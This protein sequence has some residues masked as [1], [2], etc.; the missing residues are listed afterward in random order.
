MKKLRLIILFIILFQVLFT[1]VLMVNATVQYVPVELYPTWTFTTPTNML[2]YPL[3]TNY[4]YDGLEFKIRGWEQFCEVTDG[5]EIVTAKPYDGAQ[6]P[7]NISSEGTNTRWLGW[8]LTNLGN[9]WSDEVIW[10]DLTEDTAECLFSLLPNG[11][12]TLFYESIP[13]GHQF[14][15]SSSTGAGSNWA[16]TSNTIFTVGDIRVNVIEGNSSTSTTMLTVNASAS[17]KIHVSL[18]NRQFFDGKAINELGALDGTYP[19]EVV[20]RSSY[21]KENSLHINYVD[22]SIDTYLVVNPV[23]TMMTGLQLFQ[24]ESLPVQDRYFNFGVADS[25]NGNM[26]THIPIMSIPAKI[27][28]NH[29]LHHA[30]RRWWIQASYLSPYTSLMGNLLFKWY[31]F[32]DAS[33][34]AVSRITDEITI[35]YYSSSNSLLLYFPVTVGDRHEGNG[36]AD[37]YGETQNIITSKVVWAF[38]D[39]EFIEGF[40][41]YVN[42]YF[43]IDGE[44]GNAIS[45]GWKNRLIGSNTPKDI[46]YRD[47]GGVWSSETPAGSWTWRAGNGIFNMLHNDDSQRQYH[48]CR[49]WDGVFS[50]RTWQVCDIR[51]VNNQDSGFQVNIV[52]ADN[53]TAGDEVFG[54]LR[55]IWEE[56]SSVPSDAHAEYY[57]DTWDLSGVA[58]IDGLV[59]LTDD[60]AST[61]AS[62]DLGYDS[63]GNPQIFYMGPYNP[64]NPNVFKAGF[65]FGGLMGI[66]IPA[67]L[68]LWKRPR[69]DVTV[70]LCMVMIFGLAFLFAFM[71]ME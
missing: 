41:Q 63:D 47:N 17:S 34:A 56:N 40:Y 38:R 52:R 61:N 50:G 16:N 12:M 49:N 4:T 51:Q 39:Y 42:L 62:W 11:I 69:G 66:F 3:F 43:D 15:I 57:Y 30:Q 64:I 29:A 9:F 71:F 13:A 25:S 33:I 36:T 24:N 5:S 58:F 68:I 48:Q 67:T 55:Y 20:F 53:L 1:P 14:K 26:F 2:E 37:V 23:T 35:K 21:Y 54:N 31:G 44:I 18:Y 6:Y 19:D 60:T 7:L 32:A 59:D 8:M 45:G 65:F 46:K 28:D 22:S 70:K 27:I 10:A